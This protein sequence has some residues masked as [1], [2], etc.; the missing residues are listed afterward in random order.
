MRKLK[1]FTLVELLVVVLIIG[2]L[3]TLVVVGLSGAS[4]KA[5]DAKTKTSVAAVGTALQTIMADGTDLGVIRAAC[6]G[7]SGSDVSGAC[8][9]AIEE[10]V[11]NF[12]SAPKAGDNSA[13]RV[14][15]FSGSQ[16]FLVSGRASTDNTKCYFQSA[17][18]KEGLTTPNA[19][20]CF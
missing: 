17:I 8:Q 1:A 13:I 18:D 12:S 6:G 15:I 2:I 5:K 3:A 7:D 20:N 9:S 10:M 14:K 4:N 19:A 11:G 16:T